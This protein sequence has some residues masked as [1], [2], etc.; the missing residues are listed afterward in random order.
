MVGDEEPFLDAL[1]A[2][3]IAGTTVDLSLHPIDTIKTRHQSS[4]GF[5]AAGGFRGVYKGVGSA[6]IGSAPSGALFFITYEKTKRFLQRNLFDGN[7]VYSGPVSQLC[8]ASLG[9]VAACAVRVPTEVVKQ[10][11]QASQH[12]SSL[13][14]FKH[15]LAGRDKAS[16]LFSL[17]G[18]YR[19]SAITLLRD[20][21]FTMI[22]FPIW[23]A[24]KVHRQRSTARSSTTATES[25]IFGSLAGAVAAIAT[26]PIDVI[27]TRTMLADQR[28]PLRSV[29]STILRDGGPRAFF[30]GVVPRTIW[31][32]GGGAIFLGSYQ[33]LSNLLQPSSVA[34]AG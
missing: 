13:E 7:T 10:R 34:E 25:A 18:F 29:A 32:S 8:A 30:A 17:G 14:S 26:N 6:L 23:E 31:I 3:G 4:K 1:I 2:G 21:P 20:V 12:Q 16:L 5:I 28:L 19:G 27:K 15:V 24:L 9:E 33:L 22:Q 11:V